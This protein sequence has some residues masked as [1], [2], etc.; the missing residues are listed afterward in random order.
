LPSDLLEMIKNHALQN[1]PSSIA[2]IHRKIAQTA[3]S[4]KLPVPSYATV[5]QIVRS[6]EPALLT[7]AHQGSKAYRQQYELIHRHEATLPNE[8]WQADHTLLDIVLLN[9]RNEE[10]R[11]W[12]TT[13]LDDHSRVLCG[14]FLYFS[15]PSAINT[16]LALRQ[17]IW[18]KSAAQWPICGIPQSLYVDN[19]SDFISE[20]IEQACIQLKIRLFHSPPGRPQ[21][22]G[23]IERFFRS[24]NQRFL[25]DC[26]GYLG[27]KRN[28]ASSLLTLST[29]SELFEAFILDT[30]HWEAHGA[31][32][33]S[34]MQ[35]WQA[36]AFLP[37]L[38]ESLEELDL[39]LLHVNKPR[40]VQ[41]DGIRFQS[42]RYMDVTLAAYVGEA[43]EI[44]YD[45][46]DLAEIQ[47]YHQGKFVCRAV[48][49]DIAGQTLSLREIRQARTKRFSSLRKEL[50]DALN[51]KIQEANPTARKR[52]TL[53]R[54]HND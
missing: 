50:K 7:L 51:S 27:N 18:R 40:R 36:N 46:R 35:R 37:Q 42:L 52:S 45:P 38:P 33:S 20:H 43:V 54:Y 8:L 1:P 29:F 23:R 16:A 6:I 53:K 17:A 26:P 15:A 12:L 24:I 19:G 2:H 3:K 48:C 13:I 31:T 39:L 25:C 9:E 41:R 4:Q 44:L 21:G 14:Y 10:Q 32:G 34:P 11:P 30:Y 5:Y 47:V 22:R 49:Q 28:K